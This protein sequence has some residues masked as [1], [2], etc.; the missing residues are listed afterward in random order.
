M[1]AS[2]GPVAALA[3]GFIIAMPQL[4]DPNFHR[5]VV[6]L[7]RHSEAG[8]FGV[9]INRPGNVSVRDLFETQEIPYAGPSDQPL[10]IGGPVEI[11]RHLL[12]LHGAKGAVAD[13]VT[14]LEDEMVVSDG[15]WV[16]T[17]R[18]A[19]ERLTVAADA[20][21]RCYVGYAGWGPGQLE[22]ELALGAW[23]PL[24]ASDAL[25]FDEPADNVW[26]KA[27][28]AGGIDPATLVP[29]GEVN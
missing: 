21:Y 23:V 17:A 25:V 16:V 10:M 24:P 8:A 9:V 29:G 27:L 28:R 15:I 7:L 4:S 13:D 18:E 1:N 3:P 19:L 2:Q 11:D 14:D 20:R 5:A 12:V 26:D 6:L 22:E